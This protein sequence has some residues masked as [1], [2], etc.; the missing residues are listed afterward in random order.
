VIDSQVIVTEYNPT[1]VVGAERAE[2]HVQ[3]HH[4]SAV[5]APSKEPAG[6]PSIGHGTLIRAVKGRATDENVACADMR[7]T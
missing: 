7:K 3:Q 2:L 5:I 1:V 6:V 4:E